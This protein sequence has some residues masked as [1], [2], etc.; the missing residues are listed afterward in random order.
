MADVR[1]IEQIFLSYSRNDRE[2]ARHRSYVHF[3]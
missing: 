3:D 1:Q 2:A